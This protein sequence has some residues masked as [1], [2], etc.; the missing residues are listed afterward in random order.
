M[1]PRI[2]TSFAKRELGVV[3]AF[4]ALDV[5]AEVAADALIGVGQLFDIAPVIDRFCPRAPLRAP[6]SA[7]GN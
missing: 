3:R 1:R 7:R 5:V 4:D 6:P 2:V